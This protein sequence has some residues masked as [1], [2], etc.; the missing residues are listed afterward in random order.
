[1]DLYKQF[2]LP[3]RYNPNL[4]LVEAKDFFESRES[5]MRLMKYVFS[6]GTMAPDQPTIR[7]MV[8]M[9]ILSKSMI[10]KITM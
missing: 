7:K 1:M 10:N 9:K 3:N 5:A 4:G 2:Q 6:N 8:I